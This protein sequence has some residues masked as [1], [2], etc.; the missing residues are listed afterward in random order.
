MW[1]RSRTGMKMAGIRREEDRAWPGKGGGRVLAH[2]GFHSDGWKGRRRS[3]RWSLAARWIWRPPLLLLRWTEHP[4]G[5]RDGRGSSR[6][7]KGSTW[8]VAESSWRQSTLPATMMTHGGR[9]KLH[10]L[11]CSTCK[12][13]RGERRGIGPICASTG[14]LLAL[15]ACMQGAIGHVARPRV[16]V[17]AC[18]RTGWHGNWPNFF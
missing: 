13:R 14:G 18:R 1:S 11:P 6:G 10:S 12:E 9:T 7:F 2:L 16:R 17:R 4:A 15:A 5:A 8:M 3:R